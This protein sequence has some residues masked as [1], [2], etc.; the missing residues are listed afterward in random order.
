MNEDT[1]SFHALVA[2]AL[3]QAN[4]TA[5]YSSSRH[6]ISTC[7]QWIQQSP[8]FCQLGDTEKL[9]TT[10]GWR[11]RHGDK[12]PKTVEV[13]YHNAHKSNT[14]LSKGLQDQLANTLV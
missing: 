1:Y 5:S 14:E 2:F 9:R 3:G 6:K 11:T 12:F 4:G 8:H 13:K 10:S 7:V